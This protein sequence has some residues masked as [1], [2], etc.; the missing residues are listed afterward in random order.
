MAECLTCREI[1]VNTTPHREGKLYVL[2]KTE[3]P[4]SQVLENRQNECLDL[5]LEFNPAKVRLAD[6]L[7][8]MATFLSAVK[9]LGGSV[10]SFHASRLD[11]AVDYPFLALLPLLFDDSTCPAH[12]GRPD[13]I[14]YGHVRE[15]VYGSL[16]SDLHF[17][18]YDK[19]VEQ[20]QT[21]EGGRKSRLELKHL[22]SSYGKEDTTRCEARMNDGWLKK[23]L[24]SNP[25]RGFPVPKLWALSD[26]AL[27][28]L[29]C[30]SEIYAEFFPE[31]FRRFSHALL[32]EI[33]KASGSQ[34]KCAGS[35]DETVTLESISERFDVQSYAS[36]RDS[37]DRTGR[38]MRN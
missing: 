30:P 36:R 37:I 5:R 20:R 8:P 3:E 7:I 23:I 34:V 13:M 27:V 11:V 29:P 15:R 33:E 35:L 2:A 1:D 32:K 14:P 17:A 18:I 6:A 4:F 21:A 9:A 38:R 10:E 22:M 28:P 31:L 25:F 19:S 12:F 26:E 24:T 16:H